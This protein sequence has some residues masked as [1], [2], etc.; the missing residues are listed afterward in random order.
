MYT[1]FGF[2]K[3]GLNPAASGTDIDKEYSYTFGSTRQ[4]V[5]FDNAP[6][7]NFINISYTIRPPRSYKSWQNVGIYADIDNTGMMDNTSLY[8]SYTRHLLL[9]KKLILS[10]GAYAGIRKFSRSTAAFDSNDPAVAKTKT[11]VLVYPD[12]IPGVRLTDKKY[13]IGLSLR[14]ITV[15]KLQDFKGRRIGSPS[16]LTPS[17]YFEYGRMIPLSNNLLMMPSVAINTPI[18]G[19]PI[20]DANLMFYFANR[21]GLGLGMRNTS[22]ASGI[23]QIRFLKNM[24]AGFAYSY[25][26]NL[27]RYTAKNSY[28]V[29]IGIVPFGMDTHLSGRHSIAKCPTLSY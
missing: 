7:Q 3:A 22:F 8:G 25:P 10:F 2:N 21:L 9:R 13:F 14:Q 24:T 27:M 20:V 12:I 28:E 1:Q 15:T 18:L 17:V 5:D 19:P 26:V 11:T 6:K 29:M 23:F 4:W 16:R